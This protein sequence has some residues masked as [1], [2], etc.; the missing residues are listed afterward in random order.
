MPNE[1]IPV[2]D[3]VTEVMRS[4][5]DDASWEEVQYR[6]YVRQQIKAGRAD[7]EAGRL[8]DTN[9]MRQRLAEHKKS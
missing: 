3:A 8:L 2:K 5:P 6:L 4:L 9:A 7:D 1:S